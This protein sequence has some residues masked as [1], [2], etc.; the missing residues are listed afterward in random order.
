MQFLNRDFYNNNYILGYIDSSIQAL[1]N[2]NT[3]I[4]GTKEYMLFFCACETDRWKAV[5]GTEF[6]QSHSQNVK[7]LLPV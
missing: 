7:S 6:H 4:L 2:M 5:C 3:T 1:I